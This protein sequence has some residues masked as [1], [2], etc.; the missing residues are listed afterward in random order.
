MIYRKAP[1]DVRAMIYDRVRPALEAE[2]A[3]SRLGAAGI[4]FPKAFP[5]PPGLEAARQALA[6]RVRQRQA[7]REA[8][9]RSEAERK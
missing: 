9:N 4:E 1:D 3:A 8:A 7:E 6:E 5:E 2:F